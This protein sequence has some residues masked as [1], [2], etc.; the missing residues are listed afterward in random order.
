MMELRMAGLFEDMAK[1]ASSE[2][3]RAVFDYLRSEEESHAEKLREMM[4]VQV[5]AELLDRAF[6]ASG[7]IM[8]YMMGDL[9]TVETRGASLRSEEEILRF[10]VQAEKDSIIFYQ[11]L[12]NHIESQELADQIRE[13]LDFEADHLHRLYV[14]LNVVDRASQ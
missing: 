9:E 13:L 4:S 12:L 2:N 11:T 3:L 10:A 6:E 8:S 14:L 1:R 7:E 5:N